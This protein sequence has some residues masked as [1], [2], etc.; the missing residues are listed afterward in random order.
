MGRRLFIPVVHAAT[1]GRADEI[2]TVL[3]ADAVAAA[4]LRIGYRTEVIGI[5]NDLDRLDVLKRRQP[6]AVF[7][8]VEAIEADCKVAWL[9]AARMELRRLVITGSSARALK[10]TVSKLEVKER[11]VAAGL[12]TPLWSERG[13]SMLGG[14]RVMVKPVGEH[15]S[16]GID[17]RSIV[18]APAAATEIAARERSY[19]G[20]FFAEGFVEGREFNIS[21]LEGLDGVRVLPMPETVFEDFAENQPKIVDYDAKWDAASHAYH[22]TPRKF[23]LEAADPAL[24]RELERI[25]VGVWETFGIAGY[26]RVDF[27]VDMAGRPF[28]IDINSNPCIAP[29]AGFAAAAAEAGIGFD[30]LIERVVDAALA[31]GPVAARSRRGA[32]AEANVGAG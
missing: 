28:V 26:L 18:A 20:R 5:G 19:G 15:A 3:S 10:A 12:P 13:E 21:L 31:R 30:A 23:G 32:G 7:N 1:D 14:A 8:L 6:L 11:L 17:S 2:D 9:A 27:R 29:D 25:S 16:V 24:A 22:H 4:L